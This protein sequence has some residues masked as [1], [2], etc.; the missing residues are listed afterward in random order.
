MSRNSWRPHT[1]SDSRPFLYAY[2]ILD[3]LLQIADSITL[4]SQQPLF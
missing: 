2:I 3:L 1:L 4:H